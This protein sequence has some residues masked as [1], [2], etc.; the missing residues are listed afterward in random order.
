MGDRGAKG[1]TSQAE[2]GVGGGHAAGADSG[3]P[4]AAHRRRRRGGAHV[5]GGRG[6]G[7]HGGALLLREAVPARAGGVK[8]QPNGGGASW[9]GWQG[10]GGAGGG[11]GGSGRWARGP[12]PSDWKEGRGRGRTVRLEDVGGRGGAARTQRFHSLGR[13]TGP[14]RRR[15]RAGR[16]DQQR[17]VLWAHLAAGRELEAQAERQGR[18]FQWGACAPH[19]WVGQGGW[20]REGGQ[21][22]EGGREGEDQG[23][24][25]QGAADGALPKIAGTPP[26]PL[27]AEAPTPDTNPPASPSPWLSEPG[28]DLF[29]PPSG[30]PVVPAPTRRARNTHPGKGS[31]N[32]T[33]QLHALGM[34]AGHE[35]SHTPSMLVDASPALDAPG[36]RYTGGLLSSGHAH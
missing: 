20:G 3:N 2:G 26:T 18:G 1:S 15:G 12:S 28:D 11:G 22:G 25:E 8:R 14:Q 29:G 27:Q 10:G 36:L 19:C 5:R 16:A 34:G 35:S 24:E 9:A 30:Q 6:S 33:Q 7:A 31:K 23:A 21:G 4:G 17:L 13:R 32:R